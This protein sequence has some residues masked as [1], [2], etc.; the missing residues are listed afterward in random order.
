MRVWG[1]GGDSNFRQ[2]DS[3]EAPLNRQHYVQP[4]GIEPCKYLGEEQFVQRNRRYEL[5]EVEALWYAGGGP[6]A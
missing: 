2:G 4:S 1:W 6:F 3:K 5:P